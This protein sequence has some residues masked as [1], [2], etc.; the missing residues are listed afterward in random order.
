VGH[1]FRHASDVQGDLCSTESAARMLDEVKPDVVIHLVCCS[2]VDAC[3]DDPDMARSLNITCLENVA[4]WI[5][6]NPE[7]R[8]IH[9]STDQ[10]YDG[11]GLHDEDDVALK[12]TYAK[13]K[14]ASEKVA[15]DVRGTILRTNYFGKSHTEGR[16]SLS[17]WVV[18]GLRQELPLTFFTDVMFSPLSMET[19]SE[20]I[21]RVAC[22]AV[23]GVFNLGSH[24][25]MSKRDFAYAVASRM[26]LSV[27]SARDGV[28]K[29]VVGLHA[30]R[31]RGMLMNS[32]R[33]ESTFQVS[34]PTLKEEIE[35]AEL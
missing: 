21:L 4:L 13:S 3:E 33:F 10:V 29:D 19:L 35:R 15:L 1:G 23:S 18:E 26:K 25:G 20:M 12:N 11:D 28:L 32:G 2:G 5:R 16:S 27:S 22:S 31:P 30:I 14:H 9:I 24:D 8:L 34:L 17:D 6:K 7:T